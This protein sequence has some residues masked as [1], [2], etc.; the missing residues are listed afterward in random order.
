M[1][2]FVARQPIFDREKKIHGYELLF[3]SNADANACDAYDSDT[4]TL[5]VI[6]TSLDSIGLDNLVAGKRGFINFSRNLLLYEVPLLLPNNMVTVEV[7]ENITPDQ[8]ILDAVGRLKDAGFTIAMDDFII[9]HINSPLI[10]LADIVKVD[11]LGTNSE[12]RLR[13]ADSL[14]GRNLLLLAEKIETPAAF[15]EALNMGYNFFQGY[16]FSKPTIQAGNKIKS[17]VLNYMRILSE[18]NNPDYSY[19]KLEEFFRPDVVLTYKLLRFINSIW[20]GLRHEVS[21]IKHALVLLGPKEIKKWLSLVAMS[22]LAE[23]KPSEL[24]LG[25]LVR[26]KACEDMAAVTRQ[27]DVAPELFLTG[28]FSYI[29]A[30][31]DMPMTEVVKNLPVIEPIK[32]ALVGEPGKFRD[33]LDAIIHYERAN[34]AGLS[35]MI[36]RL[37]VREEDVAQVYNRSFGWAN[38]AFASL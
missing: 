17:N 18:I 20:F 2:V 36:G 7:L 4:S 33:V 24:I 35:S 9:D 21:S 29:D 10:P 19:D 37:D 22:S 13:I 38:Q 3:R 14:N 23:G 31:T 27:T 8:P 5:D 16:F 6:S 15:D 12:D 1:Q 28:M 11:F 25:S 30:I 34:W 26:A 32:Q